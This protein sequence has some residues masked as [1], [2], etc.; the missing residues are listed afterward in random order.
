MREILLGRLIDIEVRV[1]LLPLLKALLT[2]MLFE[3]LPVRMRDALTWLQ[4]WEQHILRR[5]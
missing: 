2:E 4:F 3:C 5:R 1:N